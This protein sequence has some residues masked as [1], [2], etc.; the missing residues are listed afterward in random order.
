MLRRAAEAV[1]DA[2]WQV[3]NLDCIVFA[4]R[5]KLGPRKQEMRFRLAE[6]LGISP[7]RI[8]I[9]AKTGEQVGPV[10]REEIVAAECVALLESRE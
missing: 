10:G 5:P 2:G 3:G 9:K 7:D 1:S 6:I 8:G 4:E